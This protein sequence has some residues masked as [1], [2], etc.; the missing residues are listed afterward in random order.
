[1]FHEKDGARWIG[2]PAKEYTDSQGQRQFAPE[3]PETGRLMVCVSRYLVAVI[4]GKTHDIHDP[5]RG[6]TRCVY[7][8]WT[9]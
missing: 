8:F 7:G 1:M 3:L 5:P 9:N 6:G 2:F 4:D